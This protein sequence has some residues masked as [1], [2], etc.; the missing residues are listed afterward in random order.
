MAPSRSRDSCANR[1]L[2]RRRSND[3]SASRRDAGAWPDRT[4]ISAPV[5]WR[6]T[7]E[8]A[9]A[10]GMRDGGFLSHALATTGSLAVTPGIYHRFGQDPTIIGPGGQA[11]TAIIRVLPVSGVEFQGSARVQIA[12][13]GLIYDV[14]MAE[15]RYLRFPN[16]RG[17]LLTFVADDDVWLAPAD[18]GRAWRISADR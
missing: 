9:T 18:G 16:I 17:D 2:T 15:S 3:A 14:A 11:R 12:L 4:E 10:A 6:G 8:P 13:G 7:R 5:D 1:S